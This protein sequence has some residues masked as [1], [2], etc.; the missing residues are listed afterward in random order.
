MDHLF[1]V[2]RKEQ[3]CKS[4]DDLYADIRH[5][6]SYNKYCMRRS[7]YDIFKHIVVSLLLDKEI[8]LLDADFSDD[9]V[10]HLIGDRTLL[11]S[12]IEP[13]DL[14]GCN[15]NID[16]LQ[17]QAARN[18]QWRI[19]LFTSGTTGQPKRI[20]HTF[21]SITRYVKQSE[22]HARDIWGFAYNPTH[23]AGLQVFFQALL[24]ENPIVRLFGLARN[25]IYD[26]I[27][28]FGITNIS[29]TPT[30]YRLLLPV[31]QK[32]CPSVTRLT[33]GG[34]KFDEQTQS[35]LLEAFPNAKLINVY[36]STEAGT[37]FAAKGDAFEIAADKANLFK[38]LDDELYIHKSLLGESETI[39]LDGDW[40]RTGDLVSVISDSPLRF[41][42]VSRKHE[43]INVGGY[44]VNPLEVEQV[45]REYPGVDDAVVFAKENRIL[46]NIICSKVVAIDKAITEKD[47][48]VFLSG[49]LQE[50]KIPR[51]IKFVDKLDMTRTGKIVRNKL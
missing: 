48:R 33:S 49:R 36:A 20:S 21:A 19:T 30:F 16:T 40:Y 27:N 12:S 3:V 50:F 7:Y 35:E 11:D 22:R 45:I 32:S 43:M 39:R 42:F 18:T 6:T 15:I 2:D 47:L 5:S 34:E 25:E 8:V 9:E 37:L 13:V 44:K 23:M 17:Q 1:F 10:S 46:G 51:I 24:N 14:S 31:G 26:L 28:E 4:Y 41:K 38:V 29:A